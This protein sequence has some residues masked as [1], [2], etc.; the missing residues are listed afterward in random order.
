MKQIVQEETRRVVDQYTGEII[1]SSVKKTFSIKKDVDPFYLT[2]SKCMSILYGITSLSAIKILWKFLE[3]AQ[4]NTGKVVI[5]SAMK[6]QI[7]TDLDISESI[8]TKS[9]KLLAKLEII[10]G[11]RGEYQINEQIF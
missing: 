8:Y 2:Y 4:Y 3:E 10:S 7:L 1:D 6:K 5:S 11:S 9:L